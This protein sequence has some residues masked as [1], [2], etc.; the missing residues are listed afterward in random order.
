MQ[1]LPPPLYSAHSADCQCRAQERALRD[2]V[3]IHTHHLD[4]NQLDKRLYELPSPSSSDTRPQIVERSPS[5]TAFVD[6]DALARDEET[7]A[8]NDLVEGGGQPLYPIDLLNEISGNSGEYTDM[9]RPWQNPAD[10]MRSWEVFQ[11]QW[12]RWQDFRAWQRDNR[13]L[14]DENDGYAAYVE[15]RKRIEKRDR[16]EEHYA[17]WEAEVV[18]DPSSLNGG[19]DLIRDRRE[20]QRYY[21]REQSCSSFPDYAN[22][23]KRR[24]ARHTISHPHHLHLH[25]DPKH[26]DRL[27]TWI[28]YINFEC[29]W[30]D[31][32]SKAIER[33]K[34]DYDK[35]WQ[36]LV[37]SRVLRR[38]ETKQYVRTDQ[39]AVQRQTEEDQARQVYDWAKSEAE[40]VYTKTQKDA[41]RLRIPKQKRISLM[42]A[43][44]GILLQAKD[45]LD[46][47]KMRSDRITAYVLETYD[48]EQAKKDHARQSFL[49]QWVREQVA[50]IEIEE[51]QTKVEEAG[52]VTTRRRKRSSV[53]TKEDRCSRSSP[54]RQKTEHQKSDAIPDSSISA[55][56][57]RNSRTN[58]PLA[59]DPRKDSRST[60]Q[61]ITRTPRRSAR[62]QARQK[63]LTMAT[64]PP[65]ASQPRPRVRLRSRRLNSSL[66]YEDTR[67]GSTRGLIPQ[68]RRSP[69]GAKETNALREV[70]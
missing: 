17:K 38:G 27:T 49:L 54:K 51:A 66:P 69:R 34:P 40:T 21:H 53:S 10:L 4:L 56:N 25:E 33:L 31:K 46:S 39:C 47:V 16:K 35:A 64:E 30:L 55:H 50:V 67:P 15:W 63:D 22:A 61:P 36:E 42:K 65:Q 6:L 2:N 68:R 14:Q 44:T 60:T 24:L 3:S 59:I 37:R 23:V 13:G 5:P 11:R 7:K 26:Q 70:G 52:P 45:R 20:R 48:Y 12:R 41:T 29:W 18:A 57:I 9:L 1:R 8:Y 58:A 19:W 32:H 28:E 43:A 62:I